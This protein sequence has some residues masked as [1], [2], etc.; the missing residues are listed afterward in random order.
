MRLEIGRPHLPFPLLFCVEGLS[1][2]LQQATL[3][4]TLRGVTA[5]PRGPH[6]SHLFFVNDN[7]IFCQA[8]REDYNALDQILE[9]YEQASGQKINR[10]KTAL[11]FNH[12]FKPDLQEEIKQHFGAEVIKQHETY[13]GLPSLVG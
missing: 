4:D 10:E 3:N 8:T 6:I 2:L 11:F 13:L 1:S 9:T 5:S 12:N 7:I